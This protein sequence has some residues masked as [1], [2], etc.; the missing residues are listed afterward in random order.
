MG[1]RPLRHLP[2]QADPFAR[3]LRCG[4]R[5]RGH[6][7]HHGPA[8]GRTARTAGGRGQPAR[9]QRQHRCRIAA[10]APAY[11]Y[12][13]MYNASALVISPSLYAKT[14]Y[15]L[16]KDFTPVGG[17]TNVAIV[18]VTAPRRG[19]RSIGEFVQLAKSRQG[20]LTYASSSN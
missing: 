11:G 4:W 9:R 12:T 13:L 6:G 20:T 7:P 3:G 8:H 19:A 15:D 10:K 1:P 14:G 5:H 17:T 16:E 18:L 2:G